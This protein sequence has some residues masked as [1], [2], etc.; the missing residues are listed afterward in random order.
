MNKYIIGI[1]GLAVVGLTVGL[2]SYSR[3]SEGNTISICV[4][5]S[6]LVYVIGTG[7]RREDCKKNESLL[8]WNTQ[9]IQGPKGDTG[10]AGPQGPQGEKGD[11]GDAGAQGPAGENG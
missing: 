5:K 6:G 9:G 2:W 1:V 3:A 11:R 7:F 8:T 4:K 10:I